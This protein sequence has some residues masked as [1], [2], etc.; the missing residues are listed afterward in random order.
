M[1]LLTTAIDSNTPIETRLMADDFISQMHKAIPITTPLDFNQI[2]PIYQI[3]YQLF[4]L[5]YS[6]FDTHADVAYNLA[7]N[8]KGVALKSTQ[9]FKNH[10]YTTQNRK[11][12]KSYCKPQ[13]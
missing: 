3:Y 7:I 5:Y 6:T 10:I 12:I 9:E 1:A 13:L 8:L 11:L 2:L 4:L